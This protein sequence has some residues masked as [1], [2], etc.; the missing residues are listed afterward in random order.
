[1][2]LFVWPLPQDLSCKGDP[3]SSHATADMGLEVLQARQ[4][5]HPVITRR[6]GRSVIYKTMVQS[7][8]L[9]GSEAW[10]V[11]RKN[12]NELFSNCNGLPA[13]EGNRIRY[14]TV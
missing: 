4:P 3:T 7:V 8:T 6:G 2:S 14:N 5:P 12:G 10:D 9:H 11:N 13:K 1:V